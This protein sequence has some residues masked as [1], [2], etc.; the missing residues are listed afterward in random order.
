MPIR[1]DHPLIL[2]LEVAQHRLDLL[3]GNQ[4]RVLSRDVGALTELIVDIP[5]CD[6]GRIILEQAQVR[7][8]GDGSWDVKR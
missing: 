8:A 1:T 3:A 5:K 2:L 7:A 4:D 6:V